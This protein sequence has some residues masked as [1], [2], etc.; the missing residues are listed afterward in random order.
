MNIKEQVLEL[1]DQGYTFSEIGR[2]C[3]CTRQ[4]V[5]QILKRSNVSISDF[6]KLSEDNCV[7]PN[8]LKWW[9]ENR[10]TYP[11]FL[12]SMDMVY[13][14]NNITRLKKYLRGDGNPRKEYIDKMIAATGMPYE[15]LFQKDGG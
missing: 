11:K 4:Y 13:H 2:R 12:S 1:T 7:Y 8:I 10:M 15:E 9:N 3:G 6:R 14:Q 5:T